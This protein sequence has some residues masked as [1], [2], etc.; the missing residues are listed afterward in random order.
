VRER[1]GGVTSDLPRDAVAA[2]AN[3][4]GV[5]DFSVR[6]LSVSPL[7]ATV[8]LDVRDPA[9]PAHLDRYVV[10][11]GAVEGVEPIRL[12]VDDDLDAQTFPVSGLALDETE[13][14]VDAA[15]IWPGEA[16]LTAPLFCGDDT[17]DPFVVVDSHSVQPGETS[18]NFS[19][20]CMG[21]RGQTEEVGFL[22][23]SLVLTA[24]HATLIAL[25][26]AVVLITARRQRAVRSRASDVAI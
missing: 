19:L 2:V 15:L 6:S 26:V 20:Y 24:G 18:Y 12:T 7:D 13:A 23:P 17:P 22:R 10:R 1:G 8:V 5:D 14:M 11:R 25:L 21:P 16:K 3:E 9:V 4:L